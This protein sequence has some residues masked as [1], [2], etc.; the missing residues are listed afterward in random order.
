MKNTEHSSRPPANHGSNQ[1]YHIEQEIE[2]LKTK[3]LNGHLTEAEQDRIKDMEKKL[4]FRRMLQQQIDE[5][6]Q[7]KLNEKRMDNIEARINKQAF[8][9]QLMLPGL[10]INDYQK[11]RQRTILNNS[12]G[13]RN[14]LRT[15]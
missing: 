2:Q 12:M 6:T 9:G 13:V 7:Q 15:L 10:A 4:E 3:R 5:R 1:L 8:T 11:I 14:R